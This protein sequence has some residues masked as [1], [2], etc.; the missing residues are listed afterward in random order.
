MRGRRGSQ[1]L[2]WRQEASEISHHGDKINDNVGNYYY[3]CCWM[4]VSVCPFAQD[5]RMMTT[6]AFVKQGIVLQINGTNSSGNK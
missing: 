4:D 5:K 2:Q 6:S 3:Y 1:G